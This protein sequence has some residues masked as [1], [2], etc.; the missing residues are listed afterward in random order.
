MWRTAARE[1]C[2]KGGRT[3]KPRCEQN[4]DH[5]EAEAMGRSMHTAKPRHAQRSQSYRC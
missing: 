2:W 4:I 5:G 1:E 3:G